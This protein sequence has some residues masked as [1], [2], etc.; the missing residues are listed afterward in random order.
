MRPNKVRSLLETGHAA[1]G[2]LIH[3]FRNPS[4][5]Q[6]LA[7]AGY[8]FVFI[9]MEHGAYDFDDATILI[10]AARAAG[11]TALARATHNFYPLISRLLDAG[12]E[13]IMLPRIETRQDVEYAVQCMRY[14]PLGKRGLAVARGHND[15]QHGD[16]Y[17]F[18]AQANREN[19]VIIQIETRPAMDNLDD[20]LSVPGVDV[21]L[22]GPLDLSVALGLPMDFAHAQF[23]SAIQ[24]VL[25]ACRNHGVHSA[26]HV[27]NVRALVDFYQHGLRMLS[28]GNDLDFLIKASTDTVN[29][30]RMGVE[31]AVNGNQ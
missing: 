30:L 16:P 28:S 8:D 26:M 29:A 10:Q 3:E 27:D 6:I 23:R 15:Y 13:G 12:A 20:L 1:Y 5:M 17:E 4:I 25:Q 14:P 24:T 2:C 31:E 9:D 22:I 18:M 11:L 19:L 21:A 7:H